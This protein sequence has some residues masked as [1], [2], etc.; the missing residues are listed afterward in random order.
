MTLYRIYGEYLGS[1]RSFT[2]GLGIRALLSCL[3]KT[4]KGLTLLLFALVWTRCIARPLLPGS[5]GI[6]G[7]LKAFQTNI[8]RLIHSSWLWRKRALVSLLELLSRTR[9]L[10]CI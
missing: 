7:L 4:R 6:F 2:L 8:N 10:E 3:L 5:C 9:W 1:S